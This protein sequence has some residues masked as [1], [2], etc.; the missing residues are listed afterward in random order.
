ADIATEGRVL[1]PYS[2]LVIDEAHQLEAAATDQLTYRMESPWIGALVRRLSSEGDLSQALL[3]SLLFAGMSEE[4]RGVQQLALLA[5]QLLVS[6]RRVTELLLAFALQLVETN[7]A[8]YTQ[9]LPLDG[10]VRSQPG[11]GEVE[12]VWEQAEALLD[13]LVSCAQELAKTLTAAQW[14]EGEPTAALLADLSGVTQRLDELLERSRRIIFAPGGV[15]NTGTVCWLEVNDART[16]TAVAEAPLHISDIVQHEFV[17]RRRTTIFTGA[18]LRS[19]ASFRFL[20]ERLGLWDVPAAI[21]DSPFDYKQC[22]LLYM[23][24]DLV[25]P[26]HPG[27]QAGVERAIVEAAEACDG[28]TLALFTSNSH[29]RAT[30]D[31][32]RLPLERLGI[33]VLQQGTGSRSRILRDF[34][35]QSRAVLMGTRTFWEGVDLPGDE[36]RC[37]IICK[38]PFAVPNDPLIAARS[39]EFEDAFQEYML[40]DAVLRFR[41]GF[42]R[43][44]RRASDRGVVVLLDSR[45]WRKEYGQLFLDALPP[46]TVKNAPISLLGGEVRKWLRR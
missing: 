11:W 42:G 4:Q 25:Q 45:I 41:Q 31:A 23:P 43:L 27:W 32:I 15:V 14:H 34:R 1:P 7:D 33:S 26:T 22:V 3:Q 40:P 17:H 12:I 37:L 39:A 46:C 16:Q 9:R 10:R 36:L 6:S 44:I 30:A 28:R 24:S 21:V 8:G 19:G 2:H 5:E 18:T 13:R 29:L 38:L 35:A 20:R